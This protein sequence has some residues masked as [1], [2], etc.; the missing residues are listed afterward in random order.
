MPYSFQNGFKVLGVLFLLV[1][2]WLFWSW[3][4]IFIH[5]SFARHVPVLMQSPHAF[6]GNPPLW[7]KESWASYQHRFIQAD[8]RVKDF[9]NHSITTS[10]GQSYALL[11]AVWLNDEVAFKR[12]WQWTQNNLQI[13]Q[14]HRL[15]AWKWGQDATTKKWQVLDES[16]ASDAD[17]DIAFALLMAH[18][19]WHNKSYKTEALHILNDIWTHE[20]TDSAWGHVLLPGDW[21]RFSKV[22]PNVV[23]V[24]PSYLSPTLYRV[25]AQEDKAHDW[26]QL[27]QSSYRIWDA[28]FQLSQVGLPPDWLWL[29]R[30]KGEVYPKRDNQS[31]Y[32]GMTS[33]Y[34]YEA[35]R[36][37]WR[38]YLDVVLTRAFDYP[39]PTGEKLLK[40]LSESLTHRWPEVSTLKGETVQPF[41]SKA[42]EAGFWPLLI[43]EHT[44]LYQQYASYYN[45]KEALSSDDYYARNWLWFA[46]WLQVFQQTQLRH[47][48]PD[49]PRLLPLLTHSL[50]FD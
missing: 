5:D 24:N 49:S 42:R 47:G 32:K 22:I 36:L 28:S 41:G 50:D 1:L 17:Q 35:C 16:T 29:N 34:G 9:Y 3:H 15:L 4:Y 44:P 39:N 26:E 18:Q 23:L 48:T 25:F 40:V 14:E 45:W 21:H 6:L 38:L 46:V 13:R 30:S 33:N 31:D 7:L 8:G 11:Q 20:V 43:L 12:L 37:P 10:E 27:V 19:R 2:A